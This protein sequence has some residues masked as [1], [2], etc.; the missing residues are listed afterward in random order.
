[1][2]YSKLIQQFVDGEL[3]RQGEQKLFDA[4]ASSERLRSELRQSV[5][6]DSAMN[7]RLSSYAPSVKSTAAVFSKLGFSG[8]ALAGA[9]TG[10]FEKTGAF[11]SANSAPI[12]S[13][14]ASAAAAI[15]A[16]LLFFMPDASDSS[17]ET[18][19]ALAERISLEIVLPEK[20]EVAASF[21]QNSAAETIINKRQA[22]APKTALA[23]DDE[24][25][26]MNI[27]A[28]DEKID[29]YEAETIEISTAPIVD[30]GDYS[31]F[32]ESQSDIVSFPADLSII[33][34]ATN[35]NRD[36]SF[37]IKGFHFWNEDD[38][39]G[40][41]TTRSVFENAGMA[42]FYKLSDR[43]EAGF[44][45]RQERFYQEFRGEN[46]YGFNFEYRQA[47]NYVNL[48]A[49]LKYNFF[50]SDVLTG[51]AKLMGG[52]VATGATARAALGAEYT[53]NNFYSFF[54]SAESAVLGYRHQDEW[55]ISPKFGV[56]YGVSFKF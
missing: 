42:L 18:A 44:D 54:I 31:A 27:A 39:S 16:M 46:Q 48:S 21:A 25:E 51:Y 26:K 22:P 40:L 34:A 9:K 43:W 11:F 4:M 49:G 33:G 3:D 56:N 12:I 15:V 20:V 36:W 19:S 30:N 5:A 37:E 6:V 13:G 47:P 14:L 8:A 32:N 45:V 7:A 29:P 23:P 50:R 41:A 53:P 28:I 10:F 35:Y 55:F 24:S 17:S 2:E 1:M 38:I 52:G